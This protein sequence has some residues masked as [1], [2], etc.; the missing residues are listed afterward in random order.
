MSNQILI[1]RQEAHFKI[2]ANLD[3][4]NSSY[5]TK[6]LFEYVE[7]GK[8]EF[9]IKAKK[10]SVVSEVLVNVL[11]G[12]FSAVLYDLMKQIHK[13]LKEQ[14][15]KGLDVKP[16]YVFLSDRQYILTGEEKDKLPEK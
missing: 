16:V 5:L 15:K 6:L 12:L 8:I 3:V 2:H 10:G 13:M 4:E 9:E 14:R 7:Q 11:G 1:Q